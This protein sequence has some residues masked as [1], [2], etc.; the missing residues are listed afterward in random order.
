MTDSLAE[1][2]AGHMGRLLGPDFPSQIGLAVSG[3]GDSMAM[4]ALC[5]DWARVFGVGLHVVTI[6]HGL[7][8]GSATE[9]QMV[10]REC[11]ALGHPHDVLHWH[12]DRQGNLQD[13]ARR[14]R[15]S[16]IEGW[17]GEVGHVLFAHTRDDVAETLLMRL[18]RGSGVE[19]LSAMADRQRAPGGQWQVIRPLL[20]ETRADLRHYID[21][22]RVP[23]V[24]DPSNDDPAFERVR[25]RQAIETLGLDRGA[26]A[27]TAARMARARRALEARAVDVARDA[28]RAE[29]VGRSYSGALLI[30]RD[31]LA[32]TDRDTQLRLLSGALRWV[33]SAPYRPREAALTDL[34]DRLLAGGSGTLH[35]CRAVAERE[36]IRVAREYAAVKG[37][38]VPVGALWDGRWHVHGD[39]ITGLTVRALGPGGWQQLGERPADAPPHETAITLPAVFDG[40]RLIAFRP[41]SF[42]PAHVVEFRPSRG[43]FAQSLESR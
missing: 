35:G 16:L 40:D 9:A 17:R 33:A 8:E 4:L 22:L 30:D 38:S 13:A 5:H 18:A 34:L 10:A 29:S 26:L 23:Y 3:G 21:T 1:R 6:D 24:D 39:E 19:G 41:T 32:D 20:S 28:T 11:A 43:A 7:R 25:I 2:F 37:V 31:V 14:G 27:D 36:Q 42:G 12:W 15:L